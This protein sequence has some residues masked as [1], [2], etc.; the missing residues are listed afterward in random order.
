MPAR[1]AGSG[2]IVSS[3]GYILTNAHVVAEADEVTVRLTDRREFPAKVI[4]FDPRTDVAVI[5]IEA[6]DLP[7][8]RIGDPSQLRARRMGAGDRLAVRPGQQRDGRHRERHS[9]A[10]GGETTTCRSSRPTSP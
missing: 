3:D 6:K 7:T 1:G 2:F 8:V 9:R 4:G 5:K 10:V